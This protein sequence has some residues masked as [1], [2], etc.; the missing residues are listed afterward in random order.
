MHA[1][2]T[3]SVSCE[4]KVVCVAHLLGSAAVSH[5]ELPL[6]AIFNRSYGVSTDWHGDTATRR[7]SVDAAAGHYNECPTHDDSSRLGFEL[8]RRPRRAA[9]MHTAGPGILDASPRD[10][11]EVISA[12]KSAKSAK[13]GPTYAPPTSEIHGLHKV[14][15]K[16]PR[17]LTTV[18]GNP[19]L[20]PHFSMVQSPARHPT[21]QTIM[22]SCSGTEPCTP[23]HKVPAVA[24]CRVGSSPGHRASLEGPPSSALGDPP[25]GSPVGLEPGRAKSAR[26]SAC[27]PAS[28]VFPDAGKLRPDDN[29]WYHRT[30]TL[31]SVFENMAFQ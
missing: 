26:H 27:R 23:S 6:C 24:R 12:V 21:P 8:T 4:L 25:L 2:N 16:H 29:I 19:R 1:D 11:V 31:P 7:H 17:G 13:D 28:S 22:P 5:Q 9:R 3:P 18:R 30:I 20:Q 14:H 15:N 10:A